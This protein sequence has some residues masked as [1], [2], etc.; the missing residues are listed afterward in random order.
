MYT[1]AGYTSGRDPAEGGGRREKWS[2][3]WAPGGHRPEVKRGA[4][5]ERGGERLGSRGR[6][7]RGGGTLKYTDICSGSTGWGGGGDGA[8]V[9]SD[10]DTM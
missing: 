10:L 9:T 7:R 2:S 6:T 4:E 1:G 8:G 5:G 3:G